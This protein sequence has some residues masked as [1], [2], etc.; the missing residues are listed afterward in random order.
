MHFEV[1]PCWNVPK[2]IPVKFLCKFF[3]PFLLYNG[4][5]FT[6]ILLIVNFLRDCTFG[7]HSN[8]NLS[9]FLTTGGPYTLNP[10]KV[11]SRLYQTSLGWLDQSRPGYMMLAQ[12][13]LV[14][15]LK[16]VLLSSGLL[17]NTIISF[18]GN[19]SV[20]PWTNKRLGLEPFLW[21]NCT[22]IADTWLA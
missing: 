15:K 8:E 3:I 1:L 16:Y 12:V 7:L 10:S 13:L 4:F 18:F 5:S 21:P 20:S 2:T 22:F 9:T 19:I 17:N 14:H 6:G 11:Q